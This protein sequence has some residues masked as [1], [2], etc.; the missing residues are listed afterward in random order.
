MDDRRRAEEDVASK[1]GIMMRDSDGWGVSY[2]E[3]QKL[4][5]RR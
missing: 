1:H 5:R 3:R 4:L 2:D